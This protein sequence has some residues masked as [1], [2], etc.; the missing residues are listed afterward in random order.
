MRYTTKTLDFYSDRDTVITLGKFDGLHRGH[1]LLI[2][3]VLAEARAKDLQSVVFTFDVPP[4][5]HVT[6]TPPRQLLLNEE[7]RE[8]LEALGIDLVIECPFV[9]ELMCME[10]E[11]FVE[12]I[13]CDKLHARVIVVGRDFHFGHQRAGDAALLQKIGREAGFETIV[14]DKALYEGREISSTW[15]REVLKSGKPELAAELLGYPFYVTGS[16]LHGRA[17]G[18]TIGIPTINQI[19]PEQKILPMFGV[20]VAHARCGEQSWYG[21]ANVGVKPTVGATSF[22][23]VETYL[24]DCHENL[25]EQEITV[26][27]LSFLR[28]ETRF[29][30]L[31][32]LKKQLALDEARGRECVA[33]LHEIKGSLS[34]F[35]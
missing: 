32:D 35:G 25:Y 27:L 12:K 19:P 33:K 6:H 13:L 30:S 9:D 34:D 11:E 28:P 5:S 18:R 31:E 15:I 7:R 22:A 20:Y 8:R 24:F 14:L 29:A 16:V 21:I 23:G 2:D 3:R 4:A 17:L 10:P 26:S 1:R